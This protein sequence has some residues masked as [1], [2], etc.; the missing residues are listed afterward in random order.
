MMSAERLRTM[1]F[2]DNEYGD[3]KKDEVET[4]GSRVV[5]TSN[6]YLSRY[7]RQMRIMSVVPFLKRHGH[8]VI[9]WMTLPQFD[10]DGNVVLT[11]ECPPVVANMYERSKR[12]EDE[13]EE[14]VGPRRGGKGKTKS[15]G[16]RKADTAVAP[17]E[18]SD[19]THSDVTFE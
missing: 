15:R 16:K 6:E 2:I 5:A 12:P 17:L 1:C 9:E 4:L 19:I 14:R 13:D 10:E 8:I 18:D 11:P 7:G 3:A